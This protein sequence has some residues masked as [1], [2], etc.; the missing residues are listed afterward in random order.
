MCVLN[1][2]CKPAIG[3][4]ETYVNTVV[5]N[6][7]L[8]K[9]NAG[10]YRH[11]RKR[12]KPVIKTIFLIQKEM[13][14]QFPAVRDERGVL[15]YDTMLD[16]DVDRLKKM[17]WKYK[18]SFSESKKA[19]ILGKERELCR[20]LII[21][22]FLRYEFIDD[23]FVERKKELNRSTPFLEN[24]FKSINTSIVT[25]IK[26]WIKSFKFNSCI[27]GSKPP[28]YFARSLVA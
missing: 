28:V 3:C 25:L 1:E 19:E 10:Q 20:N 9:S 22:S 5:L 14:P 8:Q 17:E 23:K 26:Q 6:I 15:R 2:L 24:Y 18:F 27:F 13:K 16:E 11:I 4:Y 7:L 21:N 12:Q